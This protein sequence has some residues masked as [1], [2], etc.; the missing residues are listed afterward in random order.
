MMVHYIAKDDKPYTIAR[1]EIA[2]DKLVGSWSNLFVVDSEVKQGYS[3]IDGF[4]EVSAEEYQRL[5]DEQLR[6][7]DDSVTEIEDAA[8]TKE[9]QR[10]AA[11]ERVVASLVAAGADEGDLRTFFGL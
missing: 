8:R 3:L 4:D 5:Q 2:G 10:I 11:G 7:F 9:E 6:R 1:V